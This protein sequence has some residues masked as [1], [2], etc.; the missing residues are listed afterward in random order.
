MGPDPKKTE[1]KQLVTKVL[2]LNQ[3]SCIYQLDGQA[4]E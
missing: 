4:P 2:I 1:G 3:E